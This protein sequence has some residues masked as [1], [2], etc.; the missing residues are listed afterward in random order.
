MPNRNIVVGKHVDTMK[1]SL[2]KDFR[3]NMT[4]SEKVLWG[5]LRS[6]QLE[7]LH[8]RRQQ[9]IEGFIV[10]FYCH[11]AKLVIEVDGDIHQNQ[12]EYDAER[13]KILADIGLRIVRISNLEIEENLPSVLTDLTTICCE[14]LQSLDG[15]K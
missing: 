10:D 6:N 4:Q 5:Y 11:K 8:F 9:I 3:R 2:A 12:L 1:V 15:K 7:G 13:D 14:Q